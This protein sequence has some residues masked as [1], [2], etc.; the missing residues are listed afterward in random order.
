[1]A[2]MNCIAVIIISIS[3]PISCLM[4]SF[5]GAAAT[6]APAPTNLL[7]HVVPHHAPLETARGSGRM[8]L[9]NP[10]IQK[11]C[12]ATSYPKVCVRSLGG[13][14]DEQGQTWVDPW[15]VDP[16]WALIQQGMAGLSATDK[17]I[18]ET[19][20]ILHMDDPHY[21]KSWL[22]VCLKCY[23]SAIDSWQN[24]LT[25]LQLN[26]GFDVAKHLNDVSIMTKGCEDAYAAGDAP[27]AVHMSPLRK[28]DRL[29]SKMVSNAL[30][31]QEMIFPRRH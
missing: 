14:N 9:I 3:I 23:N 30:D 16:T 17:A 27:T 7:P 13:P 18:T 15:V 4:I 22:N 12:S 6:G 5:P 25:S 11:I 19:N 8:P 21:D 2:M 31:I 28:H 20:R 1:M 24:A 29:I 10:G 26:N